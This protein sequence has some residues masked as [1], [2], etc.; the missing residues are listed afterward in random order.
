MV[1]NTL[2][3]LVDDTRVEFDDD[4]SAVDFVD[5]VRRRLFLFHV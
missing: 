3:T 1:P 5:E 2:H 4:G